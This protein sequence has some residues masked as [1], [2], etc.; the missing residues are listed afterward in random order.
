MQ[1]KDINEQSQ[2]ALRL[3]QKYSSFSY[4]GRYVS[5]TEIWFW[6]TIFLNL[7]WFQE[8]KT[9]YAKYP[10]CIF[11]ILSVEPPG[12]LEHTIRHSYCRALLLPCKYFYPLTQW[13]A[14]VLTY[15]S[16]DY[17]CWCEMH[18]VFLELSSPCFLPLK[19]LASHLETVIFL[20][21]MLHLTSCFR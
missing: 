1:P 11:D 9:Y 21:D 7:L 3:R 19:G 17:P 6:H 16:K 14:S 13:I 2:N 5:E 20:F 10:P 4:E 8:Y 12:V 15:R 18:L